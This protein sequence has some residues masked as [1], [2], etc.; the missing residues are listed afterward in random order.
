MGVDEPEGRTVSDTDIVAPVVSEG[1]RLCVRDVIG[2][3][4][5][6]VRLGDGDM[7]PDSV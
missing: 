7:L 2:D 1:D 6:I 3:A 4:V 5:G